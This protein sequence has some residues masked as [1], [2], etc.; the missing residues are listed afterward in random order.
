MTRVAIERELV[1]HLREHVLLGSGREIALDSPLGPAVG[2]D[3][4]GLME[5]LSALEERFDVEFPDTL[6]TD[7]RDFTLRRLADYLVSLGDRPGDPARTD[8]EGLQESR[9]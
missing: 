9:T 5:F 7:R 4:L 2:L 6:W 1:D 8:G 3:S